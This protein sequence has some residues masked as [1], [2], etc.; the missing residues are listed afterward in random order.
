MAT[1]GTLTLASTP[2]N[3]GTA[4]VASASAL[5]VLT[6]L[7]QRRREQYV[8]LPCAAYRFNHRIA[9]DE[10]VL[11]LLLPALNGEISMNSTQI[12]NSVYEMPPKEGMSIAHFL[13]V[14]DV[15]RS[16]RYYEKVF[17]ARILTM[18]D[19]NAPPYLQLANI[20]MILNVGGGPTPDKPTVTLSVPDPNHLSSFMNFRVA[21]IQACYELWKSRGAEFITEPI[22]KYGEIRCY[23]RDPDGY[24]IEVGQSTGLKYG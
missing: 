19:G 23:I 13:T 2:V 14:A 9:S 3:N 4:I 6:E 7:D 24:I 8:V 20:W 10:A 11:K 5:N 16:A 18:G 1:N 21:D 15:E 12:D 22:P 17:G